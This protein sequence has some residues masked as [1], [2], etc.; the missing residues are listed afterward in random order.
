MAQTRSDIL[1]PTQNPNL[2]FS[3]SSIYELGFLTSYR[4]I[5]NLQHLARRIL[6]FL[7]SSQDL[8]CKMLKI[9]DLIAHIQKPTPVNSHFYIFISGSL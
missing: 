2:E 1:R 4:K 8:G 9:Q 5:L 6:N 3:T 7:A